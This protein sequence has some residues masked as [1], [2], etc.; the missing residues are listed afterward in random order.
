MDSYNNFYI[1]DNKYCKVVFFEKI[2]DNTNI[3]LKYKYPIIVIRDLLSNNYNVVDSE[4]VY[5][6]LIKCDSK[7]IKWLE[8]LYE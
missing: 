2:K 6:K 7:T 8:L 1:Y 5:K 4:V 3:T